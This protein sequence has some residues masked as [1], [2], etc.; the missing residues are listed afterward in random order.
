MSLR[1]AQFVNEALGPKGA[2]TLAKSVPLDQAL[3]NVVQSWLKV[4][5][6]AYHDELPGNPDTELQFTYQHDSYTGQVYQKSATDTPIL[7]KF[8]SE[9]ETYVVAVICQILGI[10]D[11][12][13]MSD[14]LA[15]STD[16]LV[17][18]ELLAKS[19]ASRPILT[20][21]FPGKVK[22]VKN[23]KLDPTGKKTRDPAHP[24]SAPPKAKPKA[25]LPRSF[26]P[27]PPAPK[28]TPAPWEDGTA[29][30]L[31]AGKADAKAGKTID[32]M[33]QAVRPKLRKS[34]TLPGK[35]PKI[36]L[37][38]SEIQAVCEDCKVAQ[39]IGP[40][41]SGCACWSSMAKSV[42]VRDDG[43]RYV[44]AFTDPETWDY[45]EIRSFLQTLVGRSEGENDG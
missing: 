43:P 18:A 25:K 45:E 7:A 35:Q 8:E 27:S 24:G 36:A 17:K 28:P 15:K 41:F 11:A 23:S 12:Q 32:R 21:M 19:W 39:F 30:K 3:P 37:L 5:Q 2:Q 20:G 16:L 4:Q 31:K 10:P 29:E 42:R 1:I 6:P 13:I 44:F 26:K 22:P 14:Q 38:K 34:V 33:A 40:K 9:P